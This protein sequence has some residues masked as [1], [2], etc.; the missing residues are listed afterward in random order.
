MPSSE[1][2]CLQWNDFQQNVTSAFGS[3]RKD[4]DF[5]NVTLACEEGQ[6]VEAHKVILAATSPFFQNILKINP[7]AHPLIYMR[8]IN[9]AELVAVVDFLY[10]GVANI[11]E[12]NLDGFLAL[13]EE[14]QLKGFERKV[15]EFETNPGQQKPKKVTA[16]NTT[17]RVEENPIMKSNQKIE[18]NFNEWEKTLTDFH[19]NKDVLNFSEDLNVDNKVVQDRCLAVQNEF[20]GDIKELDEKVK[21]LMVMGERVLP[22]RQGKVYVCQVCGKEANKINMRDHIEAKHITGNSIPCSLCEKT[23]RTRAS[24]RTHKSSLHKSMGSN[25]LDF[26]YTV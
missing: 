20:S 25:V 24:L 2:F 18:T 22:N 14:L 26:N 17:E 16:K 11:C 10:Y 12:N 13:A 9:A 6:Q 3:L 1:K 15:T 8:G 21:S 4:S 23:F 19:Q 7:H 5:T